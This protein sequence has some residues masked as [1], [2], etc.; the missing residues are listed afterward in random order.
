MMG[1]LIISS[2]FLM[3]LQLQP[4]LP[5][6]P[7]CVLVFIGFRYAAAMRG[8][9]YMSKY[10]VKTDFAEVIKAI[11]NPEQSV[12]R[13]FT[14]E[15]FA[16]LEQISEEEIFGQEHV[17]KPLIAKIR[18]N[19]E[20]PDRERPFITAAFFGPPGVGKTTLAKVISKAIF[21][22][23]QHFLCIDSSQYKDH[24][25][26]SLNGTAKGY[27]GSDTYGALPNWLRQTGGKGVLLIDEPDRVNGDPK[28]WIQATMPFL[29]GRLTEVSTQQEF[30]TRNTAILFASNYEHEKLGLIAERYHSLQEV[31]SPAELAAAMRK[32]VMTILDGSVFPKAFLDRLD[33]IGV[34][35]PL[36][37]EA[38]A[39]IVL[40]EMDDLTSR[41][42]MELEF[43][44]PEV[45]KAVIRVA[46]AGDSTGARDFERWVTEYVNP[47]LIA[48]KRQNAK[49][50]KLI[51]GPDGKVYAPITQSRDERPQT[52]PASGRAKAKQ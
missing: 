40:K 35:A 29:N 32:E 33:F 27:V 49:K 48:A 52:E 34:F 41:H 50:V 8:V 15:V 16:A 21:K 14:E 24:D 47:A 22:S 7:W 28:R 31:M 30:S 3:L 23:P 4:H 26:S 2:Y 36:T 42:E 20:V 46:Q 11:K 38:M 10:R 43:V 37:K 9:I 45:L 12:D 44:D 18:A 6:L 17:I 51:L 5:W 39:D 19:A 1:L 25:T 13:I